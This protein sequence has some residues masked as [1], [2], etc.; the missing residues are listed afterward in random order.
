MN[1]PWSEC[2]H[3]IVI[4]ALPASITTTAVT[5]SHPALSLP[6][7][8]I[9]ASV[10]ISGAI[11]RFIAIIYGASILVVKKKTKVC[12]SEPTTQPQVAC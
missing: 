8:E 4:A 2:V 12:M 1:T 5:A 11:P 6:H 9:G 3:N 10:G 7:I